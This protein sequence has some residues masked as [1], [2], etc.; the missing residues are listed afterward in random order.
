L[1]WLKLIAA[2]VSEQL[3]LFAVNPVV[4]GEDLRCRSG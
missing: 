3:V 2:R 4:L 1:L